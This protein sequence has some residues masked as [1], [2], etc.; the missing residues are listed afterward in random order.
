MLKRAREWWLGIAVGAALTIAVAMALGGPYGARWDAKEA[1][2][3]SH[4]ESPAVRHPEVSG[5]R[6]AVREALATP[7]PAYDFHLTDHLGSEASL[8]GLSGSAVLLSFIYTNCPEACPL[9]TGNY[10]QLQGDFAEAVGQGRLSLLLI[11]TDPERDTPERLREYTLGRGGRWLFLTGG[12]TALRRVWDEYGVYREAREENKEVVIYHSYKTYLID[13]QGVVRY[14]YDGV[15]YPADIAQ[16]ISDVL[17]RQQNAS[18]SLPVAGYGH[19]TAA[20]H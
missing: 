16:D 5:R 20:A 11:T 2:H 1:G 18:G 15:W 10:L 8:A 7:V 13:G 14:R 6:V 19:T 4:E 9:L 12:L 3:L 17:G